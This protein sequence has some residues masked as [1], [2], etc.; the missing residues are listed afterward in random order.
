MRKLCSLMLAT[1]LLSLTSSDLF[2]AGPLGG[3]R[4]LPGYQHQ[5][6]QGIDSIVGR[7]V[8]EDG[9]Q[10][11]YEIGAV[12]QPGQPRFGGSFSDRPKLM[13]ADQLRWYREQVVNGQSVHVAYRKDEI[14]MVSYPAKGMNVSVTVRSADEMAEALLMILTYPDPVMKDPVAKDKAP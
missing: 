13:P 14:L 4:L 12:S 5:P 9:L 11:N 3:M 1:V 6:L 10:I 7:I 2:A 8:K